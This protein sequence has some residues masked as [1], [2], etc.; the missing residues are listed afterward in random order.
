M[1]NSPWEK[2]STTLRFFNVCMYS[3]VGLHKPFPIYECNSMS[4]CGNHLN[5]AGLLLHVFYWSQKVV[6]LLRLSIVILTGFQLPRYWHFVSDEITQIDLNW[7]HAAIDDEDFR[8]F[9]DDDASTRPFQINMPHFDRSSFNMEVAETPSTS[10]WMI[11]VRQTTP[12]L[13]VGLK[14]A[15]WRHNWNVD[16]VVLIR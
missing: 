8:D 12:D 15:Q 13:W 11:K 9:E 14:N 5:L 2:K 6:V 16:G 1:F 7:L 3:T 10:R 4:I